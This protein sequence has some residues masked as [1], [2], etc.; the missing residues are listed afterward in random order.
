MPP[1]Q[2]KATVPVPAPTAPSSTA[3]DRALVIAESTCSRATCRPRM[4]FNP[5]SLVSPTSAL[6]ER[7]FS[8]PV[9]ASVQRTVAS[10]AVPTD[11]VLVSTIGDSIV[12]SS[13]T[14]VEP[15]SLPN[16]LPMNTAPVTFSRNRLPPCGRTAVTPV[17][18][19]SPPTMVV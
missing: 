19:V 13:C 15:A 2:P 11:S 1:F 7:T 6:T 18:M 17:R 14:C 3:P 10:S 9:C 12:P 16:A 8:L 5:P 4:S